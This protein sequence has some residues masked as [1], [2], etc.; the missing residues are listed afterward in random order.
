MRSKNTIL[1]TIASV[2]FAAGIWT[3][4]TVGFDVDQEGVFPCETNDDCIQG[5]VCSETDMVCQKPI[6]TPDAPPCD[7][8]GNPEGDIDLDNDG[9]GT[10]SDRTNCPP[11][12][13][14]EDCDDTDPNIFPGAGERCNGA[15]DDCDTEVDEFDCQSSS[16]ECGS[17]P[18]ELVNYLDYFACEN[19]T[20]VMQPFNQA[21]QLDGGTCADI[22]IT[23]NSQEQA[24]TYTFNGQ[25][26]TAT[27]GPVL[28]CQ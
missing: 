8:E 1:L 16:S 23:C 17:P 18:S 2:C 10:G 11:S 14:A 28:E 3:G 15:D 27:E 9:Y 26:Y 6:G 24:F 13:Q 19:N 21:K 4:C 22:K 25:S 5:Y 12:K 20:C 7:Q